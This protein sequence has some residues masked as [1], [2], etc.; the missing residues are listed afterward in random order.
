MPRGAHGVA[1]IV[2]TIKETDQV[3]T[4]SGITRGAAD[5]EAQ[6]IFNPGI[7]S[8]TARRFD[9][10][11]MI[12]ETPE[13]RLWESLGHEDRGMTVTAAHIRNFG[14]GL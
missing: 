2:Q 7:S 14:A 4:F 1:Q 3:K 8:I 5:F 13:A 6:A 11:L 12:I 9:R 10:F